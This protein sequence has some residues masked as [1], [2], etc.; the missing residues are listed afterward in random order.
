MFTYHSYLYS[1]K[2]RLAGGRVTSLLP[3]IFRD[4]L[5][6]ICLALSD[7]QV[8]LNIGLPILIL[9]D[10]F[11]FRNCKSQHTQTFL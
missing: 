9:A 7:F 3:T 2:N 6:A 11:Q 5:T 4:A 8:F 10:S 1:M